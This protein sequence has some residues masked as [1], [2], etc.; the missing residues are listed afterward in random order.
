MDAE[1]VYNS[2]SVTSLTD[3]F[4]L[5]QFLVFYNMGHTWNSVNFV[6]KR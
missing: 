6:G 1:K 3:C 4:V 2:L 5:K